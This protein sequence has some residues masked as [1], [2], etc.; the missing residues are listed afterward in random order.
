MIF[1]GMLN[2]RTAVIELDGGPIWM[3]HVRFGSKADMCVAKKACPLYPPKADMCG[4]LA[5]VRFGPIADSCSE[6]LGS[7]LD[8]LVSER[9]TGPTRTRLPAPP[10]LPAMPRPSLPLPT[11]QRRPQGNPRENQRAIAGNFSIVL[12]RSP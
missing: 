5:D 3:L 8:H 1:A 12:V 9:H 2:L 7:L 11:Q 6:Q 10:E 4:A